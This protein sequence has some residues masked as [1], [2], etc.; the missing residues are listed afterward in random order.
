MSR[1]EWNA[2]M[3]NELNSAGFRCRGFNEETRKWENNRNLYRANGSDPKVFILGTVDVAK[4]CE[5]LKSIGLLNNGR[6]LYFSKSEE[7]LTTSTLSKLVE[8]V[9]SPISLSMVC[10][11]LSYK[12]AS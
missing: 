6:L 5:Y 3:A 11:K 10:K 4:E 9:M 12:G 8:T 7:H 1:A 2:T